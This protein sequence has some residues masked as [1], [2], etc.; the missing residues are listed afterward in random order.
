MAADNQLD[1]QPLQVLRYAGL[2]NTMLSAIR[3]SG[4]SSMKPPHLL[5]SLDS[6]CNLISVEFGM[7]AF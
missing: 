7:K 6:C 1:S 4:P 3:V 2:I 5:F